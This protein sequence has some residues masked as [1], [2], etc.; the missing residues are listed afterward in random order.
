VPIPV[1]PVG[2]VEVVLEL[3]GVVADGLDVVVVELLLVGV[4]VA[5][6]EV[7]EDVLLVL[8]L[9]L[10]LVVLVFVVGVVEVLVVLEV[11]LE[12]RQSLAAR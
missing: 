1:P 6:V 5:L 10:V 8:V 12:L 9:V 4:V 3:T 7:V 11:E 2:A